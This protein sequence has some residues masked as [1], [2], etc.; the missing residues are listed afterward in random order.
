MRESEMKLSKTFWKRFQ[1][2][3]VVASDGTIAFT[4]A[5]RKEFGPLFA[6]YG[7]VLAS[8]RTVD[9]FRKVI[10][11]VVT[12]GELEANVEVLK[13]LLKRPETTAQERQAIRRILALSQGGPGKGQAPQNL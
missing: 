12:P 11:E 13:S 5:G 3:L 2:K 1:G 6:K 10:R 9:A 4:E 7:I 8:V